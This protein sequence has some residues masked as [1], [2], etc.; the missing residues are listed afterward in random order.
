MK[1]R[2]TLV[3]VVI[4]L[5]VSA[6]AYADTLPQPVPFNVLETVVSMSH[7]PEGLFVTER[8]GKVNVAIVKRFNTSG[9]WLEVTDVTKLN[10]SQY[11]ISLNITRPDPR[12]M[13]LQVITYVRT[14]IEIDKDH[15]APDY[16]F[17]VEVP[18][19]PRFPGFSIV[20]QPIRPPILHRY[21]VFPIVFPSMPQLLFL[22]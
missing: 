8:D 16:I 5:S 20:P 11:A 7:M 4:F 22:K 13:V 10:D 6:K 18:I 21:H 9:H 2:I 1:K 12:Q 19:T 14:T 15:L 17:T 3:L